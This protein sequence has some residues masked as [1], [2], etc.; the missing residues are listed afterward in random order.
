MLGEEALSRKESAE[1][2]MKTLCTFVP[3]LAFASCL[4]CVRDI[5]SRLPSISS[6]L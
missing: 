1:F 2:D 4:A 3:S 6:L 5:S